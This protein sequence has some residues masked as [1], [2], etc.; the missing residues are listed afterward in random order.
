MSEPPAKKR[1]ESETWTL[2][3]PKKSKKDQLLKKLKQAREIIENKMRRPTNNYEILDVVLDSYMS[4]EKELPSKSGGKQSEPFTP[5]L[6]ADLNK[7]DTTFVSTQSASLKLMEIVCNHSQI[8]SE[9]LTHQKIIRKGHVIVIDLGC[10]TKKHKYKWASSPHLPDSGKFLVNAQ[11]VH[12]MEC[13]G[14]LPVTYQRF[15]E[16][17]EIGYMGAQMRKRFRKKHNEAVAEAYAESIA[18]ARYDE[19][20]YVEDLNTGGISV[21]SDARQV[22][23]F[24]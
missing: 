7:K 5:Y 13:S 23:H 6:V 19:I 9:T 18:Q 17:S 3:I 15:C 11:I 14:I 10:T 24:I 4:S 8:C 1:K 21:M 22:G 12:G 20:S 2:G 16:A